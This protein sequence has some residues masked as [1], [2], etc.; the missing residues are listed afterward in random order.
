MM[1][2]PSHRTGLPPFIIFYY[3][4]IAGGVGASRDYSYRSGGH[5]YQVCGRVSD[6]CR[7]ERRRDDGGG[8][9]VGSNRP[10]SRTTTRYKLTPI[11]LARSFQA[12]FRQGCG[13]IIIMM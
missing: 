3:L 5:P 10:P 13:V 12:L 6:D 11:R 2:F 8:V 1:V 4:P 9:G 7:V